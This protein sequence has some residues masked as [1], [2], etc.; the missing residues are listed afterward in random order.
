[1]IFKFA[2]SLALVMAI[3]STDAW[4]QSVP[5]VPAPQQDSVRITVTVQHDAQPVAGAIVR[6]R[7]IGALSDSLGIA[8]LRLSSGRQT[9]MVSRSGFRPET[10]SVILQLADTA[11]TVTLAEEGAPL[12]AVVVT[13]TRGIRRLQDEPERIEILSGEDVGEKTVMHPSNSTTL[14]SELPGVRVQITAPALGSA[15][16]RIQGLRGRYALLLAD[17]LPLYGNSSEG[18]SFLQIPSLDL[19]QA[20]V[21]KGAA[22]ALYGP[23]AGS[24]VLN[25]I[26]RR[27]PANGVPD[28]EFLFN[29]TTRGG[30]DGMVWS[31]DRLSQTTGYTFLG[32]VHNQT[33]V[34]VDGDHW[35]DIPAFRRVELRPRVYWNGKHGSSAMLTLGATDEHRKAGAIDDV[36]SSRRLS[37][38][39]WRGDVGVIAQIVTAHD[40]VLAVRASANRQYQDRQFGNRRESD[41]RQSTFAEATLAHALGSR[42]QSAALVGVSVQTDALSSA[43][44]SNAV[45]SFVTTSL[46]GQLTYVVNDRLLLSE[47]TRLDN[48]NRFGMFVSPRASALLHVTPVYAVRVSA[49]AGI[50][51]PTPLLEATDAVGLANVNGFQSLR[52]ERLQSGS[53]DVTRTV[54]AL[55]LNATAF[56]SV[57]THAVVVNDG[58][59]SA[60][61]TLLLANAPSPTRTSGTEFFATYN[62]EPVSV[63]A[64]YSY[65][66]ATEWSADKIRQV[67]GPLLPRHAGGVDIAFEEDDVGTRV[68][69]EIFYTGRQALADDPYRMNSVAFTTVGLLAQQ[70]LGRVTVF[71]NGEN[72]SNVRQTNYSPLLLPSRTATGRWTTEQWAPLDGRTANAGVRVRF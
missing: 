46:F 48:H 43:T 26:S 25:L 60:P 33:S 47:T 19:A 18:L 13:S 69:L 28:R 51:A 61:A 39:T 71:V 55:E 41:T 52:V 59:A 3:M 14:L 37:A 27:P 34:D 67:D 64:L 2:H 49:G 54:G 16:M 35:S 58:V 44:L 12:A 23:T 32:G 70:Q 9:L 1:M 22:T 7:N 10:L 17:G 30:T 11:I 36:D 45:Y 4:A 53:V 65:T 15:G 38:N 20:E 57:I 56:R 72:L 6:A 5:G 31:A 8:R 29:G 40:D 62:K 42:K 21:V 68:G 66:R 24:G 50:F 63:T